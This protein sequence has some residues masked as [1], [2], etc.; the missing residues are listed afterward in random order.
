MKY[1]F[2]FAAFLLFSVSAQSQVVVYQHSVFP[3]WAPVTSSPRNATQQPTYYVPV[4]SGYGGYCTPCQP[5]YGSASGI[6]VIVTKEHEPVV[7]P[8]A[9]GRILNLPSDQSLL[10]YA[11]FSELKTR[12]F[13]RGEPDAVIHQESIRAILSYQKENGLPATGRIDRDLIL[14]LG[15]Q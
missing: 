13:Y 3:R 1:L 12:G 6:T 9:P 11:V 5:F 14:S 15:I 7:P 4:Y 10:Q 8:P 2:S